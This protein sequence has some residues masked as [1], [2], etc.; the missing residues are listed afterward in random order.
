VDS[1]NLVV[2]HGA[3]SSDP[4]TRTLPSGGCL[5]QLNVTT[6]HPDGSRSVPL[7]WFDPEMSTIDR[8]H[9][10][11]EI[12]AAGHVRR[13]F[14]RAGGSTQSRTEVVIERLSPASDSRAVKRVR[15]LVVAALGP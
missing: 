1:S 3:L 12:V 4:V 5:A 13:R 2:L 9:A 14:F 11:A 10:G 8:L 6:T 15:K 7:A